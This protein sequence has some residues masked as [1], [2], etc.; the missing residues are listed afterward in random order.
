MVGA[1]SVVIH[2]DWNISSNNTYLTAQTLAVSFLNTSAEI[3]WMVYLSR[4]PRIMVA[5]MI[6]TSCL[7]ESDLLISAG[8][9]AHLYSMSRTSQHIRFRRLMWLLPV[10]TID[11]PQNIAYLNASLI[12]ISA[13]MRQLTPGNIPL[14]EAV[15]NITFTPNVT[16][17]VTSDSNTLAVYANDTSGNEGSSSVAFLSTCKCDFMQRFSCRESNIYPFEYVSGASCFKCSCNNVTLDC[18]DFNYNLFIRVCHK[19]QWINGTTV[20][21]CSIKRHS[22]YK[23]SCHP[24]LLPSYNNQ[25]LFN[26]I[27]TSV[28][29]ARVSLWLQAV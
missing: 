19:Y 7:A 22:Q 29:V 20:T 28:L 11:S 21:N 6:Q 25:F 27:D 12:L 3:T 15:T 9:E 17:I 8:M 10:I 24:A 26:S 1:S 2:K 5:L 23:F 13:Q 4:T 14:M 16:L 18:R